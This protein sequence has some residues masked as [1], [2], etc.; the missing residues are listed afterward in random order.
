MNTAARLM[1]AVKNGKAGA[2]IAQA[3]KAYEERKK[4]MSLVHIAVQK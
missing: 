2:G 1:G 4:R 3:T